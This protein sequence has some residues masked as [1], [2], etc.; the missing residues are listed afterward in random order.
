ML[1]NTITFYILSLFL[2][3]VP[4]SNGSFVIVSTV[5]LALNVSKLLERDLATRLNESQ[6]LGFFVIFLQH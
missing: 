5:A 6:A 3:Y 4:F 2:M 1:L